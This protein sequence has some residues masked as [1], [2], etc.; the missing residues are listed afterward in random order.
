MSFF[1]IFSFLMSLFNWLL[2]PPPPQHCLCPI[3]P[4]QWK[5]IAAKSNGF[6]RLLLLDPLPK[7]EFWLPAPFLEYSHCWLLLCIIQPLPFACLFV[8]ESFRGPLSL[9]T[10]G[11][12]SGSIAVGFFQVTSSAFFLLKNFLIEEELQTSVE[13]ILVKQAT[14]EEPL[15]LMI[16]ISFHYKCGC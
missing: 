3:S 13:V 2:P 1:L 6:F 10:K 15:K 12:T 5:L 11:T 7:L 14:W 16:I 4:Q 8:N 9:F